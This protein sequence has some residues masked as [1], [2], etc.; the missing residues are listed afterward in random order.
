M[1]AQAQVAPPNS[2]PLAPKLSTDPRAPPRFQTFSRPEQVQLGPPP[3]FTEP[4]SA[5]GDTGF[6]STNNRKAKAKKA[7]AK[8]KAP[9]A[10]ETL[11]GTPRPLAVSPYQKPAAKA[12]N[13]A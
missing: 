11:A 2:D 5:A 10:A 8:P 13:S 12:A 4:P 7:K 3:V 9:T 1:D 6:D